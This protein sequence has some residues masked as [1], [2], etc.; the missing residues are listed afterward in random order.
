M[1][2]HALDATLRLLAP[3]RCPGCDLPLG[4][5]AQEVFCSACEPLLERASQQPPSLGAA[6]YVYAGPMADALRRLKYARR[7]EL[8]AG[9]GTLLAV[10]A[11]AY[12][13]QVDRVMPLPL[14]RA[15][16]RERGFNQSAL[17][18]RPVARALGLPLDVSS[19]RRLRL[20]RDQAGLARAE[21]AEN[22]L[23]AF[24]VLGKPRPERVLLIDDVR[25]TGATLASAASALLD[26]GFREVRTLALARAEG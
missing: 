12:A 15:R 22:V 13:G 26:R 11:R 24:V 8:A 1:I 7:T 5:A 18:A 21:R 14:H 17:L 4:A 10:A 9:L 6:V 20:T 25:T 2:A 23:G 19:L 16:L 3:S